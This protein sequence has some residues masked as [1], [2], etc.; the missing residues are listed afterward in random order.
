M[1]NST[2]RWVLPGEGAWK[3]QEGDGP[4]ALFG[5]NEQGQQPHGGVEEGV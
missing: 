2:V 1:N 4:H 5:L 3:P